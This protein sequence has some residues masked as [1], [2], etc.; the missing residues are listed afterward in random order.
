MMTSDTTKNDMPCELV[1]WDQVNSYARQLAYQI[2]KS[3]IQIDMIIAIGRGGYMPGRLLSDLLGIMN[4]ASFK[5]EHYHGSQKS[6]QAVIKYPLVA[7]VNEQ[8]ILLVD[9]V[10]DSG[11]TFTVAI[12]HIRSKG[13]P[14]SVHTVV[15]HHKSVSKYEP[16]YFAQVVKEWRWIIYP[17]AVTEDLSVLINAMECKPE[18]TDAVQKKLLEKH[19]IVPSPQQI[20]DAVSL[21]KEQQLIEQ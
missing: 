6:P 21:I 17:W 9:D 8:N 1:T 13:I 12:D 11:D 2:R 19:G 7:D 16:D 3:G 4:L 14:Y 20:Q 10:S 15:L 5:I 18:D